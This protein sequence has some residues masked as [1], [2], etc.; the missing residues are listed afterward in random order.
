MMY[1]FGMDMMLTAIIAAL[2]A[3]FIGSV[4]TAYLL[5][6]RHHRKDIRKEGSGNVG[7]LNAYEVTRSK[8]L[9]IAV[10]L[11]DLAKGALPLLLLLVLTDRNATPAAAAALVG[12]VAG[13]NYSPWIGWKGGRGLAPAAGAALLFSPL[14]IAVWCLFWLGAFWRTKNVHVGN[15]AATVLS[16]FVV[17]IVPAPFLAVSAFRSAS[18]LPLIVAFFLLAV[19]VMLRHLEPLRAMVP[20]N[21]H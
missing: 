20:V 18:A 6:R 2:I 3:F 15:I 4:P 10:L 9:G 7:T 21:R 13:H 16:P 17:L 8:A 5:V 11:L 1:I 14:F 19:L 12:V